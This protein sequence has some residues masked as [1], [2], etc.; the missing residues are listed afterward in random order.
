MTNAHLFGQ[1]K[2][3]IYNLFQPVSEPTNKNYNRNLRIMDIYYKKNILK[4]Y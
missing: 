4:R 3:E 2:K 1:Q